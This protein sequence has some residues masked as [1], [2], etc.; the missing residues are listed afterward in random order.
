[1]AS[2]SEKIDISNLLV[3]DLKSILRIFDVTPKGVKNDMIN[4]VKKLY[5]TLS[6]TKKKE[7]IK[8]IQDRL[9]KKSTRISNRLLT[10]QSQSKQSQSNTTI[11][12]IAIN[13]GNGLENSQRIQDNNSFIINFGKNKQHHIHI[14]KNEKN[15]KFVVSIRI[16]F[17]SFDKIEL[18][19]D[20]DKQQRC[21]TFKTPHLHIFHAYPKGDKRRKSLFCLPNSIFDKSKQQA[22]NFLN[23]KFTEKLKLSKDQ[24]TLFNNNFSKSISNI[25][26]IDNLIS[27][28]VNDRTLNHSNLFTNKGGNGKKSRRTRKKKSST[29]PEKGPAE[30]KSSTT[31]ET[32]QAEDKSSTTLETGPAEKS[33]GKKSRRTRKKKSSTTPETGPAEDKSSTTSETGQAEDKSSTTSETGQAEKSKGKKS[34]ITLKKKSSTTSET[35]PAEEGKDKKSKITLKKKSSKTPK[36]SSVSLNSI[37]T[38]LKKDDTMKLRPRIPPSNDIQRLLIDLKTKFET[39]KIKIKI[40]EREKDKDY[41][42]FF[43]DNHLHIYKSKDDKINIGVRINIKGT[44]HLDPFELRYDY[45][46]QS[47]CTEKTTTKNAPYYHLFRSK[48]EHRG[49]VYCFN[50]VDID[51]SAPQLIKIL[52]GEIR[53]KVTGLSNTQINKLEKGIEDALEELLETLVILYQYAAIK[54]TPID[55]YFG[56]NKKI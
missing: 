47:K 32:G 36:K 37:A 56:G 9:E 7:L 44:P 14:Y 5:K 34:K 17:D 31:S 48:L 13:L 20:Y 28:Y 19:Y 50:K 51:K 24:K 39:S 10:K 52:S 18:R 46:K 40:K 54:D 45:K 6:G 33:K 12:T 55:N 42:L 1:M 26:K 22:I 8:L 23:E 43:G 21:K 4:E 30:D 35:G 25:L 11:K 49:T 38:Q 29:T 16:A 3:E 27:Q 2:K 41:L 53:K 15:E